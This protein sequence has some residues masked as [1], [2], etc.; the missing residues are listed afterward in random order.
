MAAP[1]SSYELN[2][3][4]SELPGRTL[5]SHLSSKAVITCKDAAA[6]RGL[7]LTHELKSIILKTSHRILVV[8]V[9]GNK[10]V[11]LRAVKRALGSKQAQLASHIVL[12]EW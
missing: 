10:Y 5:E 2:S 4:N 3:R 6:A 8:H 1:S 7:P 11:S 12:S 9:P